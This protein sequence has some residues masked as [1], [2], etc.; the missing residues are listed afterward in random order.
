LGDVGS[1]WALGIVYGV[2][3]LPKPD[4]LGVRWI[5]GL[6]WFFIPFVPAFLIEEKLAG[7]KREW[8]NLVKRL[9]QLRTLD[10]ARVRAQRAQERELFYSTREWRVLRDTVIREEGRHCGACGRIINKDVDVTVDHI[11]PRSRYPDLAF[12][13]DNL[14]VLCRNCNSAKGDRD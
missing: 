7:P 9:V 3:D 13:R 1:C 11:L 4:N 5:I 12:R 14:R 6:V 2:S 8:E 10:L